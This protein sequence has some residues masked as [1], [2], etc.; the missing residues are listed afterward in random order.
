MI[1]VVSGY[2]AS[3]PRR[4]ATKA[5]TNGRLVFSGHVRPGLELGEK[6]YV[7]C[8]GGGSA[9]YPANLKAKDEREIRDD[10]GQIS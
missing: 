7:L 8:F 9:F 3:K 2:F 10:R 6:V 4:T 1:N 5:E